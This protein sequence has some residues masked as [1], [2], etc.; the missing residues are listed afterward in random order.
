V[1]ARAKK[2]AVLGLALLGMYCLAQDLSS[3]GTGSVYKKDFIADYAMA[4]ALT[5]GVDPYRPLSQL[6]IDYTGYFPQPFSTYACPHPPFVGLLFAPLTLLQYQHAAFLWMMIELGLLFA[7]CYVLLPKLSI[8]SSLRNTVFAFLISLTLA[9]IRDDLILGQLMILLLFLMIIAWRNLRV[10]RDLKGGIALGLMLAIKIQAWPLLIFLLL[11]KRWKAVGSAAG[12]AFAAFFVSGIVIGF[13]SILGYFSRGGSEV[14]PIYRN[15]Y[16]NISVASI[17]WKLFDGVG[18]PLNEPVLHA[19]PLAQSI[20]LAQALSL[21]LPVLL[22]VASLRLSI[23][24]KDFDISF[25]IMTCVSAVINPISW[26][27]YLSLLII[28]AVI[29]SQRLAVARTPKL[30]ALGAVLLILFQLPPYELLYFWPPSVIAPPI[31]GILTLTPLCAVL[32]LIPLLL[33]LDSMNQ[34]STPIVMSPSFSF[35][36]AS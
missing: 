14:I 26:V 36:E 8:R 20:G 19:Y 33:R 13:D 27:H 4:S 17:G 35:R 23:K 5:H 2:M 1:T 15:F 31:A 28:P 30:I 10:G 32:M 29:I 12:S 21:I 25:G 7:C 9:P 16:T 24:A 3:L 18:T 34:L 6:V 22:L 11:S